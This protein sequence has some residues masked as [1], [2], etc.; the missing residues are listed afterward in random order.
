MI[1]ERLPPNLVQLGFMGGLINGIE[2][3]LPPV[4]PVPAGPFLIGS[5][6]ARDEA[7]DSNELPQHLVEVP[8]FAIARFPITVAE[9][10]CFVRTG[11]AEPGRWQ[12]QLG[13]LDHPVVSVPW[14]AA[15][16][17]AAWLSEC[18]GE[19]FRLPTEAEWE[20]AARGTDGRV[21]PWGDSF[22]TARCN[23]G[24]SGI[25]TTTPVGTY[26]TGASPYGA[27]DLAGNVWEWTGSRFLPY[28]NT[29]SDEDEGPSPHLMEYFVLRG[30]SCADEGRLARVAYRDPS[31]FFYVSIDI[32]FR[33]LRA[34]PP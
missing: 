34:G 20:K 4:C 15:M 21:Y 30:G 28:P 12:E 25:L 33:I 17:F 18:T 26:P 23:T 27:Q 10:A 7:A 5:A 32:G 2:V 31:P 22:D 29:V 11:Q 8:A 19:L 6:P 24:E 16:A 9:Y 1:P 14:S 13:R 3:I